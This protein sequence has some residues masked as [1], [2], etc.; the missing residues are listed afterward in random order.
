MEEDCTGRQGAQCTV[1]LEK[2]KKKLW[3]LVTAADVRV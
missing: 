1:G 2:K 3:M